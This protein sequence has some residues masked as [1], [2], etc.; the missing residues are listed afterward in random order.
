MHDNF[1]YETRE[2]QARK[3]FIQFVTTI[4]AAEDITVTWLSGSWIGRLEKATAVAYIYGYIFPLNNA[5]A[6][7]IIRDKTASY[8]VLAQ[9]NIPAVPHFL[10]RR[11]GIPDNIN[12]T[13][14]ALSLAPLPLV[15]K[16]SIGGSGGRHVYKCET[17][18]E[19]HAALAKVAEGNKT[20]A[21][22]PLVA[23]KR[24]FRIIVLD[25]QVKAMYEKQ[26]NHGAWHHNLRLGATPQPVTD[27]TLA[28]QLRDF[29]LKTTATLQ[30]RLAAVD[31]VETPEGLAVMEVNGGIMLGHFSEYSPANHAVATA[32]YQEII[33]KS[34]Q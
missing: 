14:L 1:L 26:R 24:E 33:I 32:L 2:W 30:A 29:A 20:I 27:T 10:V 8:E 17:N 13:D 34:L 6:G 5:V 7:A 21:V 3:L 16:P 31:I 25:G 19:L 22:S 28:A 11:N 4:C 9:Q 12:L 15:I 18:A 23:V